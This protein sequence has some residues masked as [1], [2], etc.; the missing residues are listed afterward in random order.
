MNNQTEEN[1]LQNVSENLPPPPA[2]F[3]PGDDYTV[4]DSK[5]VTLKTGVP[6]EVFDTTL[7]LKHFNHKFQDSA[8]ASYEWAGIDILEEG[9]PVTIKSINLSVSKNINEQGEQEVFYAK[10]ETSA[11]VFT[12]L[13][14]HYNDSVKLLVEKKQ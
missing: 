5:I 7:V 12:I 10:E 14:L 3:P 9:K 2:P 1:N 11:Y 8:D 13:E 6:L 4:M